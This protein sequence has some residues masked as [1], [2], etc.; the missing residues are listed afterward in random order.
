VWEYGLLQKF[1]FGV[2]TQNSSC[3]PDRLLCQC[4]SC[5]LPMVKQFVHG[6]HTSEKAVQ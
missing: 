2:K 1:G 4:A 6:G 3:G 5:W